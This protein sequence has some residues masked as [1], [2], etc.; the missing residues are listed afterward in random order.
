MEEWRRHIAAWRA[1]EDLEEA[2]ARQAAATRELATRRCARRRPS[3]PP[4]PISAG[5]PE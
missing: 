2:V 3:A 5:P 4:R 1:L